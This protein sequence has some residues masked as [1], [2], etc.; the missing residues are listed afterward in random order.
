V[1]TNQAVTSDLLLPATVT[2]CPQSFR[3]NIRLGAVQ[4]EP[5]PSAR[6]PNNPENIPDDAQALSSVLPISVTLFHELFHLVM[7]NANTFPTNGQEEYN[8]VRMGR[9]T[10]ENAVRNPET[11]AAMAVAYH[12]TRSVRPVGGKRVEFY[13]FFTTRG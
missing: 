7:G 3:S 12:Y 5:L 4:M 1:S 11:L 2:L 9:M 13:G 8:I 10:A 6:I